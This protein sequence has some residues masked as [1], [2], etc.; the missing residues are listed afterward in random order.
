MTKKTEI[1]LK[2]SALKPQSKVI[3]NDGLKKKKKVLSVFAKF[4]QIYLYSIIFTINS[5][6][7]T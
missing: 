1:N 6:R 2:T 3:I 4:S 7:I 5:L